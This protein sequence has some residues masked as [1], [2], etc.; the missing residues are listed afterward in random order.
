MPVPFISPRAKKIPI[1]RDF[2]KDMT[3]SPVNDDLAVKVDEDAVK[4]SIKNLILTDKGERLMQPLLGGSIRALLFDNNTPSTLKLIQEQVRETIEE[5]EPRAT[6]IDVQVTSQIDDNVV[7]IT[8]FF[9]VNNV[10]QPISV[11]VFLERIR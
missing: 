9:Y 8:I 2:H 3:K 4:E 5:Y 6:L 7:R 1:Y 11:S 10:E